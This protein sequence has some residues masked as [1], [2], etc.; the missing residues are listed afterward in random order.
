ML[1]EYLTKEATT[2]LI[3]HLSSFEKD[4]NALF[5]GYGLDL[6][7]NTGRRNMLM[8][9]AQEKFLAQTLCE[10]GVDCTHNGKPGEADIVISETGEELEVKL[11]S[12]S[13]GSWS[14]QCDYETLV[15]KG[16]LDFIY[17]LCDKDFENFAL[18]YFEKLT[19]EDFFPPASGSR[20]KARMKKSN[21]MKKCN[22][23]MGTVNSKN[24]KM[25]DAYVC[26]LLSHIDDSSSRLN[27]LHE[28]LEKCSTKKKREKTT[29]IIKNTK[30]RIEKK[31]KKL[32]S[33]IKY[34]EK[35]SPV[36]EIGLEG[37]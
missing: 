37:L 31:N 21:A 32:L 10:L 36:Y 2:S 1:Q 12:G 28:R 16:S 6:R 34:W 15:R 4:L 3:K 35:T 25:I 5:E 8:S 27:E 17:M 22:P 9:Q 14:L 18:L 24:K 23:I 29:T 7:S 13:G 19:P 20:S 11:T 26:K 30:L 33:K